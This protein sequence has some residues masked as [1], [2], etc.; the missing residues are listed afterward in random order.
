MAT[1][2]E[3]PRLLQSSTRR[4][5]R[6]SALRSAFHRRVRGS[7]LMLSAGFSVAIIAAFV[8]ISYRTTYNSQRIQVTLHFLSFRKQ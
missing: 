5:H 1:K 2:A 8:I 6:L 7:C 3:S 4:V